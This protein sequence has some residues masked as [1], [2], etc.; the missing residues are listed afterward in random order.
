MLPLC[1]VANRKAAALPAGDAEV[2]SKGRL[3]ADFWRQNHLWALAYAVTNYWVQPAVVNAEWP[4]L[5]GTSAHQFRARVLEL[6]GEEGFCSSTF[7]PECCAFTMCNGPRLPR[8]PLRVV[9]SGHT[10]RTGRD[11]GILGRSLL[12]N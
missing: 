10:V 7:F 1:G 9:L 12:H 2:F 5:G 4:C 8:L 11:S 6:V 3:C